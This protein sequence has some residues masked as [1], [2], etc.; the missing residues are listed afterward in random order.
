[1]FS[2]EH[3]Q[4]STAFRWLERYSNDHS[5]SYCFGETPLQTFLDARQLTWDTV[6]DREA[7][8]TPTVAC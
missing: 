8:V 7:P 1:M 3:S 2:L 5:A 4:N 6:L